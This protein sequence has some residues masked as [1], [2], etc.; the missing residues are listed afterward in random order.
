MKAVTYILT[1]SVFFQVTDR[2]KWS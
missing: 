1:E 2:K